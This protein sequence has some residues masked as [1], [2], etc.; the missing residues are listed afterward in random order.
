MPVGIAKEYI[1]NLRSLAD[2][3]DRVVAFRAQAELEDIDD[4]HWDGPRT[5]DP[6]ANWWHKNDPK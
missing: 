5:D 6:P 2:S 4:G 1:A 3:D